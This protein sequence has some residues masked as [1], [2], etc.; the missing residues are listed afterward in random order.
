MTRKEETVADALVEEATR[1]LGLA[2]HL[3][4]GIAQSM[5]LCPIC[6]ATAPIKPAVETAHQEEPVSDSDRSTG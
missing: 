3:S 2:D 1:L 5:F 4:P 6:H